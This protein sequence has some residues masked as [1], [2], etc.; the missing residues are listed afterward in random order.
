MQDNDQECLI[1][2]LPYGIGSIGKLPGYHSWLNPQDPVA[3]RRD[4]YKDLYNFMQNRG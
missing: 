4:F 1:N 2:R 3:E